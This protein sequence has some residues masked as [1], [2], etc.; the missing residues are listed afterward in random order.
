MTP[1]IGVIVNPV[2]GVGGPAGLKGSD[3]IEIQATAIAR[4]SAARAGGR[5]TDALALIGRLHPG[6]RV[7]TA[8]GSMGEDASHG[9]GLTPEVVYRSTAAETIGLDTT[10]AATALVSAGAGLILFAGGD[11]TARDVCDAPL[12]DTA[13][14]GIPAGVKMYSGCFAVS[15]VAAGAVAAHWMAGGEHPVAEVEV[16]DVDEEQIR[17]GR[18]DPTLYG[19]V[20]V[21]VE[22]GRTQARKSPTGGSQLGAVRTAAAGAVE[23]M[24]P[25][26]TYLLGPGG[27]ISEVAALLGVEGTP[28][29][30]D[31]ARDGAL[32]L[33]D[34]S[35]RE[36][37]DLLD[38][39]V[40]KAIITVIGGQGFLLGR[41]NQQ[42]S[43]AVLETIGSD[44]LM[45]VA[46]EEKLIDLDGRPLL[47]DT[48]DPDLDARLE[49]Y[50]EVVT[51]P[52]TTS[53]YAVH[54]PESEGEN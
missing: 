3:G 48:G 11:G 51:G 2:A 22:P 54:A 9:A 30:V 42:I 25:G 37:L 52:Q 8:A 21:P 4:G 49:G 38:G 1:S 14:L 50:T 23:R 29:G 33:A 17:Q 44:P 27:T 40:A 41:G 46:T 43:A 19:I 35:E 45:V 53:L 20:R 18:V 15:P 6:A 47:V 26:V 34:A 12:A 39:A 32:V 36:L 31:V 5:A 28:L 13:V 10:N 7:L 24:R 16:L